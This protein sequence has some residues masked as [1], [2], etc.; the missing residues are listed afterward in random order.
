MV[1]SFVKWATELLSLLSAALIIT[2]PSQNLVLAPD[3]SIQINT[4]LNFIILKI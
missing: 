3:A 1:K 4:V 2:G